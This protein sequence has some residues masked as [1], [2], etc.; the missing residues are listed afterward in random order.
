MKVSGGKGPIYVVLIG[1]FMTNVGT[2]MVIPFLVVY[3]TQHEAMTG[4]QAG[5]LF[6]VLQLTRRGLS[7]MA[8]WA[9]DRF[10]AERALTMG[11]LLEAA[12]YLSLT[13]VGRSFPA[14]AITIALLGFGGSMSNNGA[15]SLLAAS[16]SAGAVVNLSRYYVSINAAA[17]IGPLIG[18]ALLTAGLSRLAFLTAAS[19]HLL[20]AA[21]SAVL[22]RGVHEPSAV[23]LRVSDMIAG[24]R[25]HHLVVYGTLV[26]SGWFLISQFRIALPL[27]IIHQRLPGG[28]IGPLTAVNAIVVMITVSL[29]GKRVAERG[30]VGKLNILSTSGIVLGFGWLLC[31]FGGV[32]PL[33]GAVIVISVG[34]S[35]F[36]SVVDAVMMSFAPEG[37][38]GLYLGYSTMAW[39]VG[40][41]LAG[42]TGG[43]F[44]LA[45][46]HGA[47]SLF[48]LGLLIVGTCAAGCIWMTRSYFAA[49]AVALQLP[50]QVAVQKEPAG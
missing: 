33:V 21:A 19:L 46:G 16:R 22:L 18:A 17:M 47:L 44:D 27:T 24:L 20:F 8:G 29:I 4:L 30:T 34:E 42:L 2:F 45:I 23:A 6:A 31:A 14:W 25:E 50:E 49:V 9:S 41:L 48:W 38:I 7:F 43:L 13:A 10:G 39:G 26:A 40:G 12:A 15:R 3:V 37:R 35:L 32:T 5:A 36:C 1:R 11:L 28:W